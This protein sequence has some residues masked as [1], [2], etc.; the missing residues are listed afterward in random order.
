M[1][2]ALLYA[3]LLADVALDLIGSRDYLVIDGRFSQEPVFTR[4]LASLRPGMTV[5]VNSGDDGVA[6]GALSL[7]K[8]R[9]PDRNKLEKVS[10]I[11]VDMKDYR[12]R[13]R[14]AAERAA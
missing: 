4:A 6:R 13:W 3:A 12:A 14:E 1:T 9:N 7:L 11:P 2:G 5:L 10:P 8:R